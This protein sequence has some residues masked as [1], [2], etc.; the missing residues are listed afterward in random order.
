[1][2][3]TQT[4]ITYRLTIRCSVSHRTPFVSLCDS[5]S[6]VAKASPSNTQHEVAESEKMS[7]SVNSKPA[8]CSVSHRTLLLP[9]CETQSGVARMVVNYLKNAFLGIV[10]GF[11][12]YAN[13][14]HVSPYYIEYVEKLRPVS[15]FLRLEQYW[16]MFA[17]IVFRDD[18]WFI[19]KSKIKDKEVDLY[20]NGKLIDN[21]KPTSVV[22][23]VKNDRWR[24]YQENILFIH[25]SYLR[26]KYCEWIVKDW[27]KT[28]P[29][30]MRV[31][32]MELIYMKETTLPYPQKM[33]VKEE[34]LH[35][36]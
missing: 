11:G 8:P 26:P 15:Q 31:T 9:F 28:H 14:Y 19:F 6:E 29:D 23:L 20:Q 3:F 10:I 30:S 24:K 7:P 12:L 1:L 5:Q 35:K 22:K 21:Q 25:N 34:V 13:I 2:V 18:G 16:G 4:S 32:G 36:F 17:P 33:T 27:N